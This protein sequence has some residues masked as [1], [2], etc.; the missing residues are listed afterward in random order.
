VAAEIKKLAERSQLAAKEI[1]ELSNHGLLQARET[2]K[3]LMDI[4][5]DIE[6]TADLVKQIAVSSVEQKI[7]S[8]EV[9]H[10]IQQLNR[11]TQQN[12][13][14][15]FQLSLNSKNISKQAENLK[16]LIAYFRIED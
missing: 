2:G 1:N 16:K 13:E 6:L 9:N 12:A 8:E 5:P 3:K 7:S 11:V 4:V 15:S 10:G 14:S